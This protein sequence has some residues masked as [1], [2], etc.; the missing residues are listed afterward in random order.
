M[1]FRQHRVLYF[2]IRYSLFAIRFGSRR[3]RQ[4]LGL[5]D[6]IFYGADHVECRLRQMVGVALH[7]PGKALDGVLER[8]EHARRTGKGLG[9][10]EWLAHEALDLAGPR[11]GEL[12]LFG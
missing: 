4:A 8:N 3:L 12:V 2:P 6:G 9:Y 11:H 7:Q 5:L 10:E 1:E